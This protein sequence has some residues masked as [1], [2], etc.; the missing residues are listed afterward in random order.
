MGHQF[1]PIDPRWIEN[2]MDNLDTIKDIVEEAKRFPNA[3]I[4]YN[5]ELPDV[6]GI[7]PDSFFG[8]PAQHNP[9]LNKATKVMV[10][11]KMQ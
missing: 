8:V 7:K 1:N 10:I 2:N 9:M 4:E 5:L 6:K 3:I 11:F